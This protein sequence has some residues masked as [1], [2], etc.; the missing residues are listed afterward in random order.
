MEHQQN[1]SQTAENDSQTA[2][3]RLLRTRQVAKQRNLSNSFFEKR[4]VDG[5]GP[6]YI[7]AGHIVLYDPKDVDDWFKARRRQSTSEETA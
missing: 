7:K 1:D 5:T 6:R 4:R 2:K 3:L